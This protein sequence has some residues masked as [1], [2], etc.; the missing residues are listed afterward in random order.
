MDKNSPIV[1]FDSGVGGVSVLRALVREL[2]DEAFVYFGDSANAPYGS[3][4][5]EEIRALT[6]AALTRLKAEYDFKAA[7]IACNTATSAAI[8]VLRAAWPELPV[9]GIEPALKPAADRHPGGTV[10][11]MATET[12]LREEKFDALSRRMESRCKVVRLPCPQLVEFVERGETDSPALE[13]YLRGV[14]GPYVNGKA[15]AVVLGCTHFPFAS[16]VLRRVLSPATELLD[17]SEGT[18]RNARSQLAERSLLREAGEGSVRFLNSSPDPEAAE[19]CRRLLTADLIPAPQRAEQ[20]I[21]RITMDPKERFVAVFRQ[22]IRREGAE[23]LLNWLLTTDFFEAPASARYH[24]AVAGGLCQHSLNV[25]DCL[26]AYL[27]RPRVQQVYG[28]TGEDY[29]EESIAIAALLHD[30]CK[31]G[32]YRPGF[33]NVKDERGVWQ[34][35]ATYN[36]EDEFPFGHGEKSVWM[37][38]KYMKLTDQEAFAIRYHMGFS[39]EEDARTVGQALAKFP[40]AF[41]LNVADSEATYFLEE[42]P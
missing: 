40:L 30:L 39:G 1:V 25:Y 14:L 17:G 24:S 20:P 7:V 23:E 37:V 22:Y 3:R 32:C 13:V 26:R 38:M 36:F 21:R 6:L 41:A 19:R 11:V 33:R 5:T 29:S 31:I 27:A 28:L 16:K 18:A 4:P 2:P 10:V 35:V 34:K 42:T 8:E 9:I 12:T 15:D